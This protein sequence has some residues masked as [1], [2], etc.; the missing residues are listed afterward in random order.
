MGNRFSDEVSDIGEVR[1]GRRGEGRCLTAL[2]SWLGLE[3]DSHDSGPSR[4][5]GE[6]RIQPEDLRRSNVGKTRHGPEVRAKC[7]NKRFRLVLAIE[8]TGKEGRLAA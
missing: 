3:F 5:V 6:D 2:W 1:N 7:F 4:R 8:A